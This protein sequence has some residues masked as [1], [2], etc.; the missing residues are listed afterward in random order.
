MTEFLLYNRAVLD[1]LELAHIGKDGVFG[2]RR[3]KEAFMHPPTD[4]PPADKDRNAAK[5]IINS[6]VFARVFAANWLHV[7]DDDALRLLKAGASVM[8]GGLCA[9]LGLQIRALLRVEP[10]EL[11]ARK[12][13][14]IRLCFGG[15]GSTMF[16]LLQDDPPFKHIMRYLTTDLGLD[17]PPEVTSYFSPDMKHEVAKGMLGQRRNTT[18]F[19]DIS[20]RVLG[21]GV[22]LGPK[23]DG[24]SGNPRF[25]NTTFMDEVKDRLPDGTARD[26]VGAP[27]IVWDEFD[28]FLVRLGRD[29]QFSLTVRREAR[30]DI[31]SDGN[32]AFSRILSG[33]GESEPPFI[34]ML[35]KTLSLLYEGKGIT[36]DWNPPQER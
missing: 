1:T 26:G 33:Q 11:D 15:R 8:M 29:A 27:E 3:G 6:P 19:P 35:R 2:D 28:Q 10:A 34:A 18:E 7:R 16:K 30:D 17:G 14:S 23:S 20:R 21:V 32:Y 5:A 9:F 4:Q 12:L 13:T 22:R 24:E 31:T 25:E 36:V